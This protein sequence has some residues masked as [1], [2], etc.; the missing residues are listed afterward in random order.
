[1][2]ELSSVCDICRCIDGELDPDSGAVL[3]C[4]V[5]STGLTAAAAVDIDAPGRF[6]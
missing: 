3:G 1:M 6:H 4:D 2:N 5:G